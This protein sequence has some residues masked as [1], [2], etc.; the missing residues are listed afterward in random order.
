MNSSQAYSILIIID[1][2]AIGGPG[3]GVLQLC[4]SLLEDGHKPL[5]AT[6]LYGTA[7]RSDFVD[8]LHQRSIPSLILRQHSTFDMSPYKQLVT[9]IEEHSIEIV[10]TH[11]YKGHIPA[12][13]LSRKLSL[14]WLAL[15]HGWTKEKKRLVL[16]RLLERFLLRFP[17]HVA[18]VSPQLMKE[19]S[20]I[21]GSKALTL[22]ENA[23]ESHTIDNNAASVIH[24]RHSLP[25]TATI[26]ITA[27]RFSP[28]KGHDS[29][30]RA[31]KDFSTI[32]PEAHL[33]LIGAGNLEEQ[34]KATVRSL[35]MDSNVHF[36]GYQRNL[37]PYYDSATAFVL[38]SL[39][40]G[41]PNV[42]LECMAA[43]VPFIS[44][45]VGIIPEVL[46]HQ[47][48]ALLFESNTVS[49]IAEALEQ[50]TKLS[51][52]ERQSLTDEAFK[53]VYPRFSLKARAEVFL[54]IY[55]SLITND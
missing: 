10:Q 28:E 11:G 55:K 4:S 8:A 18:T 26:F 52:S 2:L 40:E 51:T 31:W 29:L 13:F 27:G 14:P 37:R 23:V 50:F 9:A 41:L 34:L 48:S 32:N 49:A 16:Y 21:R 5:V 3:K 39:S 38:P 33:L 1:T 54:G 12:L 45:K 19:L 15:T 46:T 6:F 35:S 17:K 42:M 43:R 53:I 24:K 44:S 20:A 25:D 47:K 36:C 22:I 30:L 7:K